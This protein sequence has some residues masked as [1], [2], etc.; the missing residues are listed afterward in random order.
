MHKKL[1]QALKLVIS[2]G[3]L[4]FMFYPSTNEL[5]KGFVA[6]SV[7][8]MLRYAA[9]IAAIILFLIRMFF[10]RQLHSR[11]IYIFLATLNVA[12]FLSALV[13][14]FFHHANREW[15]HAC[16]LNAWVGVVMLGD[17]VLRSTKT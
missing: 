9:L 16:L 17:A 1:L 3:A 10:L 12:I 2:I 6:T 11:F 5:G 7:Y 13:L 8:M 15:L 14:F 4:L